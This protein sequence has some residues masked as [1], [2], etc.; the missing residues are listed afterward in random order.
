MGR[1]G[2]QKMKEKT[3]YYCEFCGTA[4][5]SKTDAQKC[6]EFHKVPKKIVK[7]DCVFKPIHVGQDRK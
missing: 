5:A 7:K 4:Y 1:I 2:R 3:L 6:E